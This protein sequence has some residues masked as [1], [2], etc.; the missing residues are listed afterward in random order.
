MRI[1]SGRV[2]PLAV[3]AATVA[4]LLQGGASD[5]QTVR[6]QPTLTQLVAQAK[7]LTNE[8]DSLG[9]QYD[10]LRIQLAH[11]KSEVRIAKLAADRAQR[12][13]EG[14]QKAVA[15][16]AAM[17]Y[18]NGG[19]DLTLQMLTSGD[20]EHFLGQ[21]STVE[22][23]N[24][25]AGMRLSTLQ[26]EQIA[27]ARAQV[28][29]KEQIATANQL[30]SEINGKVKSIHAKLAL[31]NSSAMTQA[32]AIFEKTGSYP[33]VVLPE[34]T[35]VGI[36]ALRAALT[37]R[38]KPY[39]WGAAGPDSYD[40]SGL[41]V[42]AFAQEGISLP[43]Y[44]GSLWN[45]GMHVSQADLEPGDLV[46]FGA[47]IGHVGFYIGNGLMLDAPDTGAVVR[48]EPVWWT[49]YVGAVRIA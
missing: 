29:A 26:K 23:L 5:A 39:V 40:C 6:S 44:T 24:A 13:M 30:Q 18:M 28:T 16:L 37:Q 45:S 3:A 35:T 8:V 2:A 22:Q 17:G 47:D 20:P 25:E 19:M 42:W 32:M 15:Q 10:G 38:G 31:L 49:S 48:V 34:A 41:V 9:Q 1:V 33:D 21:A 11:A 27:A 4:V 12:A 36:T 14:S 46:F 43:H 7:K